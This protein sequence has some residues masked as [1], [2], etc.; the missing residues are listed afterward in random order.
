MRGAIVFTN[1]LGSSLLLLGCEQP[2]SVE[3]QPAPAAP[4]PPPPP[5]LVDGS[6]TVGPINRAVLDLY[7]SELV[8]DIRLDTS[9]TGGGFK[10]FCRKQTALNGASRPITA[11]E[12]KLC[13][14]NGVAFVELPIAFDGVAIVVPRSNDWLQSVSVDTLERVWQPSADGTVKTWK[15]G[16]AK[17]AAEPLVLFGPGIDSGTFD[18]FT[19]SVVGQEGQSRSDYT[20][21]DDYDDLANRIAGEKG[22]LGYF[23]LAY[24]V[25]NRERLRIVPVDDGVAENGKGPIAPTRE[26]IADGSYQP[27]SRPVFLYVAAH[28]AA[29]KEVAD[30]VS[31]YLRAARLVAPDVGYVPLPKRIFE[32]AQLRFAQKKT[33]SV[34]AGERIPVG[35]TIADLLEAETVSVH[36][37][38]K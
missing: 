10:K 35:L 17:F 26:S 9:G 5:I 19:Q 29:R 38:S 12:A 18:F 21:S 6:A 32:L 2:P 23:G 36:A 24:A 20:A 31:F 1:L 28:E 33:G 4:P 7:A 25:K 11:A 14:A 13:E 22:A 15:D 8:T 37:S 27:L 30:F 3:E 34:F 16:D